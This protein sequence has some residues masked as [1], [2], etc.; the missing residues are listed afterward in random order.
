MRFNEL[1]PVKNELMKCVRCGKCRSVCPVFAE[2]RQEPAAPRGHVYM[3]QMLRDGQVKPEKEVYEHLSMCLMCENCSVNC[4]SG[5]HIHELNAAARSYIYDQTPSLS[6]ELIFDTLWTRPGLLRTT[7]KFMWGAQKSG[8]QRLARGMGLTKIL[9]GDLPQAE[10]MLSNIP[11]RSARS[12]L[13]VTNRAKGEKKLTVGYFLGCGTDVFNPEVAKATVDILT[14]NGC[15]V[16]IPAAT[17]CCGLPQIANGKLETAQKLALHNVKIFNNYRLDYIV[18][19][20]ASCGSAL[21]FAHMQFL[22]GGLKFEDD[23]LAFAQKTM[24]INSFLVNVLDITLPE[25]AVLEKKVTYHDPC[26]LSKAQHIRQEPRELLR[27]INGVQFTEMRDADRCCGG[28]GTYSLTHYDISMKILDHKMD[29]AMESAADIIA[30]GCPSCLMQLRYGVTRHKWKAEVQ[31]PVL[32]VHR[33][34]NHKPKE[35]SSAK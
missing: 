9:P 35:L 10:Q 3:V 18:S 14:R 34:L 33:A 5:I 6:K 8:L 26:H 1:P 25:S 21:S 19:D 30:T 29:C 24:D 15:E 4:P 7:G 2:I 12:T 22:F 32:L 20:C 28:S 16:I 17:K 23:A 11:F 27:R 13:P 31:H